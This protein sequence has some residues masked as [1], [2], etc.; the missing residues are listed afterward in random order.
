MV[1]LR[2]FLPMAN[3]AI[4]RGMDQLKR[5]SRYMRMNAEPPLDATSFGNRQI[6][7]VPTA[8]PNAANTN[9]H[10]EE[11]C[12]FPP[13]VTIIYTPCIPLI[14]L[15]LSQPVIS[16]F[17]FSALIAFERRLPNPPHTIRS[18]MNIIMSITMFSSVESPGSSITFIA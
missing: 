14:A 15:H 12:S 11:N 5:N 16:F 9:P 7:P 18:I 17:F 3:S 4:S 8:A 10:L 13:F 2:N 1:P 6:F